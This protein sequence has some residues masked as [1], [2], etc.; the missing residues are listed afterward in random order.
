MGKVS[1]IKKDTTSTH[2][3][4][5][6]KK[7]I[8]ESQVYNDR[9]FSNEEPAL[10]EKILKNIETPLDIDIDTLENKIALIDESKDDFQTARLGLAQEKW[11][12][13]K[14]LKILNDEKNSAKPD[15]YKLTLINSYLEVLESRNNEVVSL[16]SRLLTFENILNNF[17]LDKNIT[18]STK[19]GFEIKSENNNQL[20]VD[21]L[22]TG[23]YH[24]LYLTILALCTTVKGTVIAI[25]E[26]EMSMHVSWQNKL[27]NA[28]LKISAKANPQFIFATHSPDIAANYSN[29][30]QTEKYEKN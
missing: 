1:T 7:F 22:S 12:K 29:S 16:A 14:F 20:S 23:E 26:P 25:D 30:L 18:V 6:V 4:T 3:T 17:L 24:L 10:F 5:K 8:T 13:N 21:K 2:L 28:L 11:D 9:F 15:L 19:K 27:V